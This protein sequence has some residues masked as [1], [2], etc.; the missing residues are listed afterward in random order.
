MS[1]E[2]LRKLYIERLKKEKQ[3]YISEV[4]GISET[5]LSKFKNGKID[6]YLYLSTR[7]EKYLCS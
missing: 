2:E 1:Q 4:T 7:L 3:N 5:V 6:L